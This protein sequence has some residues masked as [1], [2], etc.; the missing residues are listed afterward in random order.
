MSNEQTAMQA[1]I[2]EVAQRKATTQAHRGQESQVSAAKL[3][4]NK[5]LPATMITPGGKI[6]VSKKAKRGKKKKASDA[7][8]E[9]AI[10]RIEQSAVK[11]RAVEDRK[12][13]RQ[14]AKTAWE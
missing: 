9:K 4:K 13:K 2:A 12:A 1:Q 6:E 5:R 11:A 8:R 14:R 3:A 10:E 7:A